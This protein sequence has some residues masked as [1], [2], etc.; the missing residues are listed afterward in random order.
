MPGRVLSFCAFV[1][2]AL[3]ATAQ[4]AYPEKPIRVVLPYA[5][6]GSGD[7]ILRSIQPGMEKRLGQSLVVDFRT[8]AGGNI[9][10]REVV[11]SPADG[12][13]LLFGP[14]NNFVIDQFIYKT[15]DW[16]PLQA[17]APITVVADTPYMLVIGAANP[18]KTYAEFA[19]FARANKGKL[20]Y[21]SPG[22]ATVPHLSGYMLS[23]AMGAAMTHVPFRGNQPVTLALMANEVQLSVHSYGSIAPLIKAG[24]VR[25]LAV[26]ADQRLRVMPEVPTATEAGIPAGVMLSNWW[27]LA[28]PRGTDGDI[29]TRLARDVRATLDDTDLQKRY[30]EQGW[31]SGGQPPAEV[32]E[33]LR[34]EAA[35]WKV[36]IEKTGVKA[37]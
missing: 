26:A 8:G 12:Y 10:V 27:G 36:I 7:I 13:T 4:G 35:A 1:L 6:G 29:V 25:A 33:R 22:V 24:K 34:R 18:A 21:G 32:T 2:S 28:A 19:A 23:D 9:G 11:K 16:D 30:A 5:A 31:T 15:I 20:N 37:D 3:A 17:L 14:T